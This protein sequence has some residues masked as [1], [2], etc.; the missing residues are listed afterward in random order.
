M[1]PFFRLDLA[2]PKCVLIIQRV[3]M[4]FLELFIAQFKG[5]RD[6]IVAKTCLY[7]FQLASV[8]ISMHYRQLCLSCGADKTCVSTS[9]LKNE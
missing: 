8:T 4:K 9:V 3:A 5:L 7:M 2:S 6:F 1:S